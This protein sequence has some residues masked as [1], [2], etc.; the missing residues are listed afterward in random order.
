MAGLEFRFG[1]FLAEIQ[2]LKVLAGDFITPSTL[3]VF[4]RLRD[5]L[6]AVRDYHRGAG[7]TPWGIAEDQPLRTIPKSYGGDREVYAEITSVW[8]VER[9]PERRRRQSATVFR[10]SEGR[11]STRV[12]LML[13]NP[14]VGG[15]EIA[16]W[17]AEI[18]DAASPGCYFHVQVRGQQEAVPFPSWLPIP[19][20]PTIL[21]APTAVVEYVLGELFQDQWRQEVGRARG[22]LD[23]WRPIQARRLVSILEWHTEVVRT[24]RGSPWTGLKITQP[25]TKLFLPD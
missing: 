11:T 15:V 8:D 1:E 21:V 24:T 6:I 17:R 7:S 19:R 23:V 20:L 10:L 5:T 12:R 4:D 13:G 18:G 14:D 16:M 25:D 9:V 3:Y 2:A 22:E